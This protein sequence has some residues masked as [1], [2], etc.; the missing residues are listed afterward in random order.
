MV[1]TVVG[2]LG[3]IGL[4]FYMLSPAASGYFALVKTTLLALIPLAIV[5]G[6]LI[7][8]DRWEPEPWKTKLTMFLWAPVLRPCQP[9]SSI[10][11]CT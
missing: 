9:A 7:R 4:T 8:I 1:L 5:V 3:L 11:R 6:F 10:Q 2:I